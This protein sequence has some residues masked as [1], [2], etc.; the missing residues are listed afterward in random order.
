MDCNKL[1]SSAVFC[2]WS[3]CVINWCTPKSLSTFIFIKYHHKNYLEQTADLQTFLFLRF[4]RRSL[5]TNDLFLLRL[6]GVPP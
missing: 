4:G 3:Q 1:H 5:L 6:S 2:T